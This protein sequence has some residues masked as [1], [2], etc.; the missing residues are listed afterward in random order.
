MNSKPKVIDVLRRFLPKY[1]ESNPALSEE[2]RRAIWAITNC[3]TAALGG[4]AYHCD[5]CDKWEYT[6]HSCNHRSCPQCG[7]G[8]TA[9]WVNRELGKRVG[10]PYFMV[11][12]TL[13]AEFRS[14][15]F[16]KDAKQA[17]DLFFSASSK[18]LAE[19]MAAEKGL[20]ADT[21][22]FTGVLHTWNQQLQFHPHIHYIVPGAGLNTENEVVTA[23]YNTYL[24]NIY[25]LKGAFREAF[26]KGLQELGWE[27][28]PVVWTRKWGIDIQPFGDGENVI[29]YLGAYVCRTAIRDSRIIAIDE[30][31][32]TVTFRWKDRSNPKQ[33]V[34]RIM[35]I[36]GV[37][38]VTRYLRHVLPTGLR[39]IRYYGFCH[40]SAKAKR[41]KIAFHTGLSLETITSIPEPDD[42]EN[43]QPPG[44]PACRCCGKGMKR[45][46]SIPP[47]KKYQPSLKVPARSTRSPNP[48][49]K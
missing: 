33:A 20:N 25:R 45:I 46:G 12:F 7:Q 5:D 10:S 43:Q 9:K 1:L 8:A 32:Q 40:P 13:P 23:K 28:D 21:S 27:V 6:A 19:K 48:I 22:G 37:E 49:P 41:Q 44:T 42:D 39:S 15:F 31:N 34:S 4:H 3:R 11:T 16:G 26:R 14:L 24:V 17:Y 38:F 35:T 30:T 2:R 18:A 29:K 47:L 36:P